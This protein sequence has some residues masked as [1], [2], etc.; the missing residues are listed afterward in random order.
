MTD[1][2]NSA[3]LFQRQLQSLQSVE[4]LLT[5][6][7]PKMME[8]ATH[9]GL[10]KNLAFHLAETRQHKVA[11]EAICKELGFEAEGEPNADL[12]AII[13]SGEQEMSTESAGKA[14]DAAII[15]SA[16]KVEQYEIAEYEKAATYALQAGKEA[17]AKR[18][19]LTQEEERQAKTKLTFLKGELPYQ[20][21]Q[22][23]PMEI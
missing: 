9:F 14:L 12:Q 6:A 17:I 3:Q 5:Q 22:D 10:K 15:S 20:R 1:T 23:L 8:K 19:R 11:I 7:I 2:I 21:A 16:I 13:E 4:A 18:L